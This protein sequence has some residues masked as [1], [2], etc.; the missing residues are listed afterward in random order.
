MVQQTYDIHIGDGRT[1]FKATL[2]QGGSPV[3]LSGL[4]VKFK[5]ITADGSVLLAET[6]TGVTVLVAADGTVQYDFST[7]A[8][9]T[10]SELYGYFIVINGIKTDH[11]PVKHRE[12]RF[13][14]HTD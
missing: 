4:T 2:L 7:L 13:R 10:E 6:V 12:L 3:N 5:L 9:H 1:P 11:F 14:I 8:P